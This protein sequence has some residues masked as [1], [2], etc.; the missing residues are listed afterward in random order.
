M[1]RASVIIVA[2]S[3]LVL[4]TGCAT[5]GG[6]EKPERDTC[7]V[8]GGVLGA[9]G[10]LIITNQNVSNETDEKL[11]G[12]SLGAVS[13]AALGWYLC[14]GEKYPPVARSSATPSQGEAPL[15]VELRA[16]GKDQ[17]GDV[18]SFE[19]DL[20]DGTRGQGPQV[21]HTYSE[22]GEYVAQVTV[23]DDDGQTASSTARI[24]VD[25]PMPAVSEPSPEPETAPAPEPAPV[26]APLPV[27]I[28]LGSVHFDFDS[29]LLRSD[30]IPALNQAVEEL[31]ENPSA[32]VQLAG[33]ASLEGT[34]RYNQKL[35]EGRA[36]VVY[37]FLVGHGVSPSRLSTVG[38]G[39]SRPVADSST[40]EGREQNRRVE[41]LVEE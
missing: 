31:K 7:F 24:R 25:A 23:T 33:H 40:A 39:E 12:G 20:G 3:S 27:E 30:A 6:W 32:R 1:I 8:M 15:T 26:S 29:V 13:G 36:Q 4:G 2:A 19:W 28:D 5:Q 16:V 21:A 22:P 10:G 34:E 14:G 11:V 35:S 37:E 38:Y 17:D 9:I 41:F 18:V